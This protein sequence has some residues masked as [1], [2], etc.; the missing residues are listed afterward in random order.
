MK[1]TI[2]L[3]AVAAVLL[4]IAPAAQAEVVGFES[5]EGYT[6]TATGTDLVGQNSW[7]L[8]AADTDGLSWDVHTY[9]GAS[10]PWEQEH[11]PTDP[12]DWT[13]PSNPTGGDQFVAIGCGDSLHDHEG[14]PVN[15]GSSNYLATDQTYSGLV[16]LGFDVAMNKLAYTAWNSALWGRA[17]ADGTGA[18]AGVTQLP[19]SG[20]DDWSFAY[21]SDGY[22]NM[23]G[24]D[25]F[26]ELEFD[27]WYRQTYVLDTTTGEYT[28]FGITDLA[29]GVESVYTPDT[30]LAAI[31]AGDVNGIRLYSVGWTGV[32]AFDNV[33]VSVVPEPATMSL[34]AIGGLALLRRRKRA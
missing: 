11:N 17:N 16:E 15:K 2:V 10:V 4:V 22:K 30:P 26:D 14:D 28:Q 8:A 5:G 18:L 23:H 34:L 13:V 33:S 20:G 25:G 27:K 24:I 12:Q 29:T 19:G 3:L 32:A 9:A 1:K 31:A 6:G 21:F 7:F